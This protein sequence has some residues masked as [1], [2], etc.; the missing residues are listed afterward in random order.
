MGSR[1]LQGP[2][3]SKFYSI[4]FIYLDTA[5]QNMA[6]DMRKCSYLF[7]QYKC[8]HSNRDCWNIRQI[9]QHKNNTL[10]TNT[11][12]IKLR[13][14]RRSSSRLHKCIKL[15]YTCTFTCPSLMCTR[16][17][18]AECSFAVHTAT[19]IQ[20]WTTSAFIIV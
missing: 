1:Y 14:K 15:S 17:D 20:T 10:N 6:K 18:A 4:H 13:F 7:H 3:V 5:F 11:T 19:S 9:L 12:K 2:L 16:T 8:L